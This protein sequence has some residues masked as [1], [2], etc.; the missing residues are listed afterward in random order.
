MN[1]AL[2][3]R[4]RAFYSRR[5]SWLSRKRGRRARGAPSS[6]RRPFLAAARG[7]SARPA[8]FWKVSGFAGKCD[9]LSVHVLS[10]RYINISLHT[11]YKL[12]HLPFIK[13]KFVKSKESL[14]QLKFRHEQICHEKLFHQSDSHLHKMPSS[15][16]VHVAFLSCITA[17]VI[18]GGLLFSSENKIL[19]MWT[20]CSSTTQQSIP[21]GGTE[22][23]NTRPTNH[24]CLRRDEVDE[25]N[26]KGSKPDCCYACEGRWFSNKILYTPVHAENISWQFL[27]CEGRWFSN[28]ILYTPVHAENIS[29]QFLEWRR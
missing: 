9:F 13:D 3:V 14:F 2:S 8:T 15:S 23:V 11:R 29:W 21:H 28:K 25:I 4:K 5:M 10:S 19:C 22:L 7:R 18:I 26:E 1:I 24:R 20:I 16:F 12:V 6:G 27:E 17:S